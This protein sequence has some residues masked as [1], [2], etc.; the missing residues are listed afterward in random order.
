GEI[1]AHRNAAP[2]TDP[3]REAIVGIADHKIPS[4]EKA[5]DHARPGGRIGFLALHGIP[6]GCA[7]VVRCP[8]GGIARR[9]NLPVHNLDAG[10]R[11]LQERGRHAMWAGFLRR[12]LAEEILLLHRRQAGM[13]IAAADETELVRV[14]AEG[15]PELEAVLQG[16]PYIL[17]LQH[18]AGLGDAAI[19]IAEIPSLKIGKLVVGRQEGMRLTVA[20]R[21]GGLVKTLPTS[22]LFGVVAIELLA[23][24]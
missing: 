17:E 24:G 5:N 11:I 8:N 15:L 12:R 2:V 14:D 23:E 19:E 10:L 6:D 18:L 22:A 7:R 3:G 21:L 13:G 20:L 4:A 1:T 9:G 16:R